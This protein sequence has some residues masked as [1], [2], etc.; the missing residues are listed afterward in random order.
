ML[1]HHVESITLFYK[2]CSAKYKIICYNKKWYDKYINHRYFIFKW[3]FCLH[4]YHCLFLLYLVTHQNVLKF[5][6][7]SPSLK[8]LL[9][10]KKRC[11]GELNDNT[12]SVT[13][14]ACRAFIRRATDQ[15]RGRGLKDV[16]A[17]RERCWEAIQVREQPLL[18][19]SNPM[20]KLWNQNA[21]RVCPELSQHSQ[22]SIPPSKKR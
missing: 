22:G 14:L 1:H 9:I 7:W 13:E 17:G 11:S 19:S 15:Q 2:I 8:T 20:E 21:F 16:E 18:I 4:Y 3:L 12:R 6:L 10:G 5:S